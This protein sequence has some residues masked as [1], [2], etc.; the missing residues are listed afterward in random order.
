MFYSKLFQHKFTKIDGFLLKNEKRL[1]IAV[2]VLTLLPIFTGQYFV[3]LDGPSHLY[4][5]KIWS[6]L[7]FESNSFLS[8]YY[9]INELMPNAISHIVLSFLL[10]FLPAFVA[11]KILVI[12]YVFLFAFSF[13]YFLKSFG[14]SNVL[15]SYFIFPF[16]FSYPFLLG[17]YN[18]SFGIVLLFYTLGYWVRHSQKPVSWKF[19]FGMIVLVFLTYIS[20]LVLFGLLLFML[21]LQSVLVLFQRKLKT[22]LSPFFLVLVASILPLFFAY[23]YFVDQPVSSV[24]FKSLS[25]STL[26]K[27]IFEVRPI[28]A[29]D[30][31]R[32]FPFTLTIS[33]VLM[34][35]SLIAIINCLRKKSDRQKETADNQKN[36]RLFTGLA[37]LVTIVLYFTLPDSDGRGSYVSIRLGLLIFPFLILY[38][39]IQK[40]SRQA[41]SI[42]IPIVLLV[43]FVLVG[44]YA[45]VNKQVNPVIQEIAGVSKLI[46]AN[47]LLA[48]VNETDTWY[49]SHY[50]NYAGLE[51]P[52]VILNNYEAAY[53]YFPLIWNMTTFPDV[54]VN[55]YHSQEIPCLSFRSDPRGA[56]KPADYLL[57]IGDIKN[58]TESCPELYRF[59]NSDNLKRLHS[60]NN[61]SLFEL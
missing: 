14:E 27:Y 54:T 37:L 34:S 1:F 52:L 17:F 16:I 36:H 43:H 6:Y 44:Q 56:D 40:F 53:G 7:A 29:F 24:L 2:C 13:R 58:L 55:G 31:V 51:N 35:L 45:L 18:F 26:V 10:T 5:A 20:H 30:Y 48:V 15:F 32:E 8:D 49:M 60:S 21:V 4:N 11:E 38:L 59:I 39:S 41:L 57:V 25:F 9:S 42:A 28:I 47:S 12:A 46:D 23:R 22:A 33:L 19:A 61:C 50:Y 3:T